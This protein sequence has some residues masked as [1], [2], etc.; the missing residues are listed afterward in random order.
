MYIPRNRSNRNKPDK[1]KTVPHKPT[2]QEKPTEDG[3]C[4]NMC[5]KLFEAPYSEGDGRRG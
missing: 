5:E 2:K 3:R 1:D 4:G